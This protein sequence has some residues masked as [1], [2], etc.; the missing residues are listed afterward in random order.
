MKTD[1][2]KNEKAIYLP[3]T[4]PVLIKI[5]PFKFFTIRGRGN[6]NDEFFG[7]YISA[8]YSLSYCVKMS[9][10]NDFAPSNYSEYTVYPLE[11]I[12]DISDEAKKL[13]SEKLDKNSLVFNLMIRQPDFVTDE[14]ADE[15]ISRTKKK[16]PHLLLSEVK[17]ETLT[18]GDSVQIMHIGS[19]DSEPESFRKMENY[20]KESGLIR[21]SMIHREIYLSD[22]RKVSPEK[23]RTVLRFQV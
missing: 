14:F 5:P 16:K 6:P 20:C 4:E 9:P 22:A 17:F 19:Y 1:W 2:K 10:K 21:K 8:L 12:W 15:V 3:K 18:D 7:E 11:G 13:K 23:L